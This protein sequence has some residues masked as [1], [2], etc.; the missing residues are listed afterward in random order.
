MAKSIFRCFRRSSNII[1]ERRW[2]RSAFSASKGLCEFREFSSPFFGVLGV[3][4]RPPHVG[5]GPETLGLAALGPPTPPCTALRP[6]RPAS[7][8]SRALRARSIRMKY[9]VRMRVCVHI[10]DVRHPSAAASGSRLPL[11]VFFLKH[12][13]ETSLVQ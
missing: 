8:G 6:W 2:G 4:L 11:K 7:G 3:G 1:I 5:D 12:F 13:I 9:S 10:P